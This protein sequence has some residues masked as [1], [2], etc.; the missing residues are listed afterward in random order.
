MSDQIERPSLEF[1]ADFSVEQRSRKYRRTTGKRQER[2]A[3]TRT[4]V[5]AIGLVKQSCDHA[6]DRRVGDRM[7]EKIVWVDP[8]LAQPAQR[9]I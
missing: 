7:R 4:S 2:N 9:Q 8:R 5:E 1:A 6:F 3:I